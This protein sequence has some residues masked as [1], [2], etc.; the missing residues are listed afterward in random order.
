MEKEHFQRRLAMWW[1]HILAVAAGLLGRPPVE[2]VNSSQFKTCSQSGFCARQRAYAG[3]PTHRWIVP[4]A[5]IR[6]E[7]GDTALRW[8]IERDDGA[9]KLQS[10]LQI[11]Q[12]GILRIRIDEPSR[13]VVRYRSAPNDIVLD[14]DLQ[15]TRLSYQLDGA[16]SLLTVLGGDGGGDG[17]VTVQVKLDE[18]SLSILRNDG[19]RLFGVGQQGFF[20][21]ESSGRP[22][23]ETFQRWTDSQ[24]YG[25]Q[26]LGVDVSFYG[27]TH[28]MGLPEHATSL[29]LKSTRSL[30]SADDDKDSVA[31]SLSS[32][33]AT[34]VATPY[35]EPYRLYNLDV[36][37]YE[38]DSPAAL[39]GTIPVLWGVEAGNPH[40]ARGLFWNNPSE[41]WIDVYDHGSF[42]EGRMA[43]FISES[44]II[45]VLF[46]TGPQV[47][48]ILSQY[49]R[50]TGKPFMPPLFSLGYHQ[51]RWNYMSQED[52]LEVNA[53]LDAHQIP[54]DVLW[55]DIEHTN[56]KCYF[57]WNKETFPDPVKMQE[58]LVGRELVLIVDPH[59][60]KDDGYALYSQIAAEPKL[61]VVGKEGSGLFEGDCWPGQSVWPDFINPL[62]RIWWR[63]QFLL[64]NPTVRQLLLIIP[65]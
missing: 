64:T 48:D 53:N 49:Y 31:P 35:T 36:F 54:A 58:E 2:A 61:G 12:G 19:T 21:V 9:V 33:V 56:G 11:H 18:F 20:N 43:H 41:S 8:A 47:A 63:K 16:K 38:L 29:A 51:C 52:L 62:T 46:F 37:E 5:S 14:N 24:P 39:Y 25:L 15:N 6:L 23:D 28:L 45:D 3:S 50:V 40:S 26:S 7:E 30:V 10:L 32:S 44:G 13:R 65:L 17:A 27:S 59:L 42:D 4:S 60:K 1:R 55:L 57:T 34:P 22:E